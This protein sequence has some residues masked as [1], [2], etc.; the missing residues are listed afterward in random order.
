MA[1]SGGICLATDLEGIPSRD[2]SELEAAVD[3]ASEDERSAALTE[4]AHALEPIDARR[5][6]EAADEALAAATNESDALLALVERISILRRLGHYEMGLAEARAG[7]DRAKADG[8]PT[9]EARLLYLIGRLHWNLSDYSASIESHLEE[10][11]LGAQLEDKAIQARAHTGLGLT[12]DRFEQPENALHHLETALALAEELRRPEQLAIILNSLGN[13]HHAAGDLDAA[14]RFHQRA[15]ELREALGS[16]RGVA[17]SLNN[18]ALVAQAKGDSEGALALF[19][20][21]E[22]IYETLGLKRYIANVHRRIGATLRAMGR[23]DDSLAHLQ[24]AEAE[25]ASLGSAEVSA[26]IFRELALLHEARGDFALALDY[27]R[28]RAEATENARSTQE[29]QR[30]AELNAAYQAER[31]EHEIALLH[32]RQDLQEVESRR[33]RL[34]GLLYAGALGLGLLV[35]TVAFL[36]QRVRLRHERRAL[37]ATEDARD[38]AEAAERLKSR[39]LQIASHDLKAP[40]AALGATAERIRREAAQTAT[41][42]RLAEGIRSDTL[43][44]ETLVRDFLDAA[45]IEESRLQLHKTPLDLE[46][47]ARAT[48]ESMQPVAVAKNQKL[49]FVPYGK[50]LP[51]LEGDTERLRQVL[52]N[53]LSNALKFTPLGGTIT[54]ELGADTGSGFVEVR[55]GGPGLQ[56]QDF[57]RIFAPYQQLSATAT[58]HEHSS[59]LGLYITRELVVLHGGRLE[60]ESQPGHGAIF[61]VVL[62]ASSAQSVAQ[63]PAHERRDVMET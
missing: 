57:A 7:L 49:A 42:E 5:A 39:L 34:E 41:V 50:K 8:L 19:G 30:I 12:Y 15:L 40:L 46:K 35:L 22:T 43:R 45:V 59:G 6:Q 2:L 18:L 10:L 31:R 25:A 17:D 60:V 58:G 3:S 13:H 62:P 4:L 24:R 1:F 16:T 9:I 48:V 36:L 38:R 26:D 20:R 55:D 27:E 47:L 28:R 32:H 51:P 14:E 44:M 56:P 54:V 53:L 29:R 23:L 33:R 52:D 61:R 21:A 63:A 37:A 11:R